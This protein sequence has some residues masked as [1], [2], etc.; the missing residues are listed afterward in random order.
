MLATATRDT[1]VG[2][3]GDVHDLFDGLPGPVRRFTTGLVQLVALAAPIATYLT[4]AALRR[5]RTLLLAALAQVGAILVV[6]GVDE[7][8]DRVSPPG[9]D[10]ARD[11]PSWIAEAHY[12]GSAYLAGVAAA[13]TVI[14]PALPRRWRRWAWGTV[15][16]LLA[17][18]VVAGTAGPVEMVAT[19]ATGWAAGLVVLLAF[20]VRD[21]RP[22]AGA[23]VAALDQG[24]MPVTAFRPASVDARGSTPWF[25]TFADGTPGFVKVLSAEERS[26]DLLFRLYRAIRLENV[27]DE[28]PF[29]SLRRTV[30]HEA[31]LALQASAVGVRTPRFVG[32]AAV[33][34]VRWPWPTRP[35]PA[36]RSTG[37]TRR[38]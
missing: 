37:S 35:S 29:A 30:E 16:A 15:A 3:E 24:G 33:A 4:L 26:A 31:L 25:A 12:P 20:G 8:V 10:A 7:A 17:G 34:T 22:G 27:G 21:R 6:V 28:R 11:G 19:M 5:W 1:L 2:L 32:L 9:I 38:R 13:V 23:I 14:A 18:R 36:G